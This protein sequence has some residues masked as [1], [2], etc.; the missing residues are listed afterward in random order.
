MYISGELTSL[1][2]TAREMY[3]LA[4]AWREDM[5]IYAASPLHE[6]FNLLKQIP[7]M[8]DPPDTEHLQRPFYTLNNMGAGGDCD[9]KAIAAGAWANLNRIPFRFVAVSK[10]PEKDLHHV[11]TEMYINGEWIAFDPTYAFNVLGRPV[12]YAKR[13]VLPR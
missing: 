3:R 6:V 10:S 9:D 12:A 11:F 7:Y 5:G 2:Q 1:E 8:P 13:V 4:W